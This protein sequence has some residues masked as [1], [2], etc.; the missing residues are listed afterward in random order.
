[1]SCVHIKIKGEKK[2]EKKKKKRRGKGNSKGEKESFQKGK[3]ESTR[4][5]V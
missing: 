2:G 4:D 3:H 5:K 1:M